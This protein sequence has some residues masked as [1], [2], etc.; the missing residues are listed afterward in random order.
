MDWQI[1]SEVAEETKLIEG[2]AAVKKILRLLNLSYSV[3]DISRNLRIPVPVVV[4]VR[5]ELQKKGMQ[6]LPNRHK[7][8][9]K[10]ILSHSM[11]M[12]TKEEK[13]ARALK[14]LEKARKIH[15]INRVELDQSFAKFQTSIERVLL[16]TSMGEVD[17]S[18]VLFIGDSDFV[19]IACLSMFNPLRVLVI[20]IDLMVGQGIKST[21][22]SDVIEFLRMDVRHPALRTKNSNSFEVAFMDPPYTPKGIVTY[23][24]LA[25][26]MLKRDSMIILS[27][28]LPFNEM[29]EFWEWIV[30]QKWHCRAFLPN[31]N[32]YVGAQIH[33]GVSDLLVLQKLDW[34]DWSEKSRRNNFYGRK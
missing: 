34:I 14:T 30:H 7:T 23:V 18:S 26:H 10:P 11:N 29:M 5:N 28:R 17:S 15:N 6:I 24:K 3:K 12:S 27:L 32:K 25:S 31:F 20:D 8:G 1:F 13:Y 4:A 33:G 21:C 9:D 2:E 16:A 19:S 22:D